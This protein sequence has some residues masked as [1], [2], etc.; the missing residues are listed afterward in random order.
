MKNWGFWN[1]FLLVIVLILLAYVLSPNVRAWF[2]NTI[3]KW[4]KSGSACVDCST[5]ISGIIT[6]NGKCVPRDVVDYEACIGKNSSAPEGS[7]CDGCGPNP[8]DES[9]DK[10]SGKG[11]IVGGICTPLPDAF[12]SKICVPA[13][14]T[15]TPSALSYKRILVSDGQYQYFKNLGNKISQQVSLMDTEISRDEYVQAYI[16]TIKPCPNGQIKV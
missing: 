16:Q 1:Y 5:G 3:S 12:A 13:S 2:C 7:D 11:I 15:V 4:K 14:A 8:S 6:S 9:S 10:F